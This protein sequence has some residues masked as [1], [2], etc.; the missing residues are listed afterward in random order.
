[1]PDL[2]ITGLTIEYSSGGYAA[3][4][5]DGL[6][7][8]AAGGALTLLLG[9]S[10]CGKT[11]LLSCLGGIL[12]PKEGSIHFGDIEVTSL[13]GQ[14]LT[15]YRRTT[16]GIVFQSFNLVPS[17]TALENVTVPL[18]SAGSRWPAAKRRATE[19]LEGV[20]LSDRMHHRPGDL[21]GDSSSASPSPGRWRSTLHSS[22]PTSRP[23]ISTTCR[24]KR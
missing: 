7:L 16:V 12:T 17:M 22:S 21:S 13:K 18:R 14:A 1:M 19:L 3:R 10:G 23:P 8:H 5:V 9:P 11:S 24:S 2:Q 20:G 15:N 6:D 4:P